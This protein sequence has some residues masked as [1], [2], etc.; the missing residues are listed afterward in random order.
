MQITREY[1]DES[2][3]KMLGISLGE[4]SFEDL[5]N[6]FVDR[7][8]FKNLVVL[9]TKPVYN[10]NGYHIEPIPL[11]VEGKSNVYDLFYSET[12]IPQEFKKRMGLTYFITGKTKFI[13][14]RPSSEIIVY[15]KRK[16]KNGQWSKISNQ[17]VI[18]KIRNKE[19]E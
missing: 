11:V 10:S 19:E 4:I 1:I 12:D 5:W 6:H 9:D 15:G 17:L 14:D 3:L 7:G 18:Y 2:F 8:D 16:N 13:D